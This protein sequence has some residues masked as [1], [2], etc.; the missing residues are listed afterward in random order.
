[1]TQFLHAC[2]MA[3]Y[4][5]A[6]ALGWRGRPSVTAAW[7]LGVGALLHASGF[8]ALH[9]ETPPIPLESFPAALSLIGWLL[10]VA[11]LVCLRIARVRVATHWVAG[12]AALFTMSAEIGFQSSVPVDVVADTGSGWMHA[13]I[14]LSTGGFSLLGLASLAGL[15]YLVK[16]RL[17]KNKRSGPVVLPSLESLDR[18]EHWTLGLGFAFLS[19]GVVTGF[20]WGMGRSPSPWNNHSLFLLVAWVIYLGPVGVR[21]VRRQHG[22]VPARGVVLGFAFLAFFYLGIRLLGAAA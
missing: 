20:A 12:I 21:L 18:A 2:A 8:L 1:M 17:L 3:L 16:K 22:A 10:V 15:G 5:S 14:L 9:L 6:S 4:V 13:H 19:L 11:Y 7:L